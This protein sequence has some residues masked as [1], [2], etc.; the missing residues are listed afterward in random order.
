M[1]CVHSFAP[2]PW[3]LRFHW[4][5]RVVSTLCTPA[6]STIGWLRPALQLAAKEQQ[7]A[8]QQ[9]LLREVSEKAG[10]QKQAAAAAKDLVAAKERE[11]AG[12]LQEVGPKGASGVLNSPGAA[13]LR[14]AL[15]CGV[16]GDL[17]R[18]CALGKAHHGL[19]CLYSSA[20]LALPSCL[21]ALPCRVRPRCGQLWR[22]RMCSCCGPR[23]RPPPPTCSRGRRSW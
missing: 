16:Q 2:P 5:S 17:L 23:C 12:R 15:G 9:A 14:A 18:M 1:I 22:P 3:R 6:H 11:M 10:L 4:R 8:E 13:F 7:V 19:L 21:P 20:A